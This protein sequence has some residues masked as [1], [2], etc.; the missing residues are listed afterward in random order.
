MRVIDVKGG[1]GDADALYIN[2]AYP[3]PVPEK[4]RVVVRVKA[5]GLNR[6]DIMQREA[7]YPLVLFEESGKI[8]GVEY[9]GIVEAKGP[10]CEWSRARTFQALMRGVGK[11]E[12]I[13]I[14]GRVF[15]LIYGSA[16]SGFHKEVLH[17]N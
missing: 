4:D 16:V 5:F 12:D 10:D 17:Q 6:M 1:K 2:D 8:L 9:S 11:R 14:G 15:G 3:D 7:K 13:K